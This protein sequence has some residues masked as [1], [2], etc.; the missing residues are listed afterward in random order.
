MFYF[1]KMAFLD[2]NT[3]IFLK[4]LEKQTSVNKNKCGHNLDMQRHQC[5]MLKTVLFSF[6]LTFLDDFSIPSKK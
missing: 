1:K 5:N 3:A 6:Y 4:M 2:Q